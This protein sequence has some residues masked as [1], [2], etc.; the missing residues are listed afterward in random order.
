MVVPE[1]PW[2]LKPQPC[3]QVKREHDS[4][5]N[6]LSRF[7]W[8]VSTMDA[9]AQPLQRY[10]KTSH[11]LP[12]FTISKSFFSTSQTTFSQPV[13]TMFTNDFWM[14][15][16]IGISANVLIY[17]SDTTFK[18]SQAISAMSDNSFYLSLLAPVLGVATIFM[19]IFILRDHI[20][21]GLMINHLRSSANDL[22]LAKSALEDTKSDLEDAKSELED[23]KLDLE[24]AISDLE[25][26]ES[27]LE[28]AKSD[29][30]DA[31]STIDHK[32]HI[33]EM[34]QGV[35]C[36]L[37]TENEAYATGN[38]PP[39]AQISALEKK[40]NA[41]ENKVI[42]KEEDNRE[43]TFRIGYKA[44]DLQAMTA[45]IEARKQAMATLSST[46]ANTQAQL[47]NAMEL[48]EMKMQQ[49]ALDEATK[50]NL[51][52]H[53]ELAWDSGRAHQE[54]AVRLQAD[55]EVLRGENERL[56]LE[57]EELRDREGGRMMG[58]E[59]PAEE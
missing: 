59:A 39:N 30:K 23:T 46:L 35:S 47:H 10:Y 3:F 52:R 7:C 27:D 43:L 41:L 11:S 2:F 17:I 5:S 37:K 44:N 56:T 36:R 34:M 24:E 31:K 14:D 13:L 49:A 45:D 15:L 8:Q 4:N 54:R 55:V 12:L 50:D 1:D 40:V 18:Y 48:L 42:E 32:D 25:D 6:G 22:K 19:S 33:I 21:M 26:A 51:V 57:N 20:M 16:M 38:P 53:L 58:W 28:E 9:S 29:L